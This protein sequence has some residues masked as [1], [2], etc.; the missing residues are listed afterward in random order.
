[1]LTN[2]QK[3]KKEWKIKQ[4]VDSC[5][6]MYADV[7]LVTYNHILNKN[8]YKYCLHIVLKNRKG[9]LTKYCQ[10]K[11]I[12]HYE[13]IK[14]LTNDAKNSI[15]FTILG[16]DRISPKTIMKSIMKKF[17]ST[18]KFIKTVDDA[19]KGIYNGTKKR[20]NHCRCK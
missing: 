3:E 15:C 20:T 1:M 17:S 8:D 18:R 6:R 16:I 7:L 4:Y 9:N 13:T 14:W 10:E 2:E 19:M 5:R 12:K 11:L